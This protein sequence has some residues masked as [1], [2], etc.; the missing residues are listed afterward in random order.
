METRVHPMTLDRARQDPIREATTAVT[1]ER[2][3]GREIPEVVD[4][5]TQKVQVG[6]P[7][8]VQAIL[9]EIQGVQAVMPAVPVIPAAARV[10]D[11]VDI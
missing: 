8:L 5:A 10:I 7:G 9:V 4:P 3:T 2:A 6:T 1:A 11:R